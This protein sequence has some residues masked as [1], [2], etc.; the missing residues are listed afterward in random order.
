MSDNKLFQ[1]PKGEE[2]HHKYHTK[3]EKKLQG[4]LESFSDFVSDQITTSVL[5]V[6]SAIIAIIWASSNY[7]SHTYPLFQH[8]NIGITLGEFSAKITFKHFTN[9]F[10]M[11]LFFFLLGLEVKREFLVGELANV[12]VRNTVI[13][14]AIG[15]MILPALTFIVLSSDEYDLKGWGVPIATDTAFAL[16]VL[17]ILRKRLPASI[18]TFI[19]ALAVIDDVGAISVLAIFYTEP[20]E[21]FFILMSSISL[22]FLT[23]INMAGIRKILPYFLLGV[24]TWI[25]IEKS[26]LHGTVAGVL[27]ALTIPARPKTGPKNFI[28]KVDNLTTKLEKKENKNETT[29]IEDQEKEAIIERVEDLAIK[30]ASPLSRLQHL[31]EPSIFIF[32]LPIFALVNTGIPIS[33]EKVIFAFEHSLTQNTFIALIVGKFVGISLFTWLVCK[34]KIG[35][36]PKGMEFGHVIG[37]SFL[38][39]IG[40]TMSIFIAEMGFGGTEDIVYVKTGIFSAS[41]LAAILGFLFLYFYSRKNL[42]KLSS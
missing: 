17:A 18:F 38:A 27:V 28:Q 21:P 23:I 35:T 41:I 32:V 20:P 13:F 24:L 36:L 33:L 7:F 9:D 37:L 34:F 16:G 14:A 29:I 31:I 1:P 4:P 2:K 3:L 42:Q 30:S 11:A 22:L 8:F 15:G 25:F 10:L 19:A 5:L 39:G 26:G 6:I 40:F 12:N